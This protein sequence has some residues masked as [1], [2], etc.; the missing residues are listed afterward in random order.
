MSNIEIKKEY[1]SAVVGYNGSAKPLGQRND[2]HLLAEIA[3]QSGNQNLLKYF[4]KIPT[5]TDVREAKGEIFLKQNKVIKKDKPTP[6][7]APKKAT[8]K[9]KETKVSKN[10]KS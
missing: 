10:A 9:K 6:K 2:I 1:L 5:L 8:S 7:P 4:V 3:I